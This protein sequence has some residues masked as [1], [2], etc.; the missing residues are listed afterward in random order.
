M[1]LDTPAASLYLLIFGISLMPTTTLENPRNETI[2]PQ[3][4]THS[5]APSSTLIILAFAAI[6]LIWGSTYLGIRIGIES[7]PP[8]LLAGARHFLT[9][10]VLYPIPDSPLENRGPP[11]GDPVAHCRGHGRSSPLHRQ[12]RSLRGR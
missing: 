11:H 1:V 2:G 10:L 9:G 7:F 8:L 4:L 12:R 6:Y 3:P 5:A